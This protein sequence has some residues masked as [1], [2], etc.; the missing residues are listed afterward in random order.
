MNKEDDNDEAA[1]AE[2]A[3]PVEEVK[4]VTDETIFKESDQVDEPS[5]VDPLPESPKVDN[6]EP[7]QE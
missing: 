3:N 4:A 1:P 2:E 5:V 7:I 6:T